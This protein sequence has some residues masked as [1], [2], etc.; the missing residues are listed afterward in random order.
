MLIKQLLFITV[1]PPLTAT[2]LQQPFFWWTVHTFT[3]VSTSLQWPPLYNSHFF[4]GQSIHSLL[5]QPPYNGHLSTTAIFVVDSPYIHSCFNLLTMATSLQQP[6]F[7]WTVHTFTLVSTSLQWPPLYNSHFFGGQSIHSLLFQPPYNGH[8]ST[9]AIFLVD[10][11]YIHSCFNLPTMATS[12]QQPFFWWTVHT[13][14]LVS[15][16][17][18]WPPLYNSDFLL[19]LRWPL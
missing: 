19:S 11:P 7:W 1:E 4:G 17:L 2:S 5:F 3:L 15:T 8:L 6:F 18:Q 13:F 9:T 16:S 12:L 14:T 10:S